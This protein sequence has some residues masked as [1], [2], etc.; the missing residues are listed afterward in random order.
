[1]KNKKESKNDEV[2]KLPKEKTIGIFSQDEVQNIVKAFIS[3]YLRG[4]VQI[5]FKCA[6]ELL[7]EAKLARRKLSVDDALEKEVQMKEPFLK[8]MAI[9]VG[10]K[11][12]TLEE[13]MDAVS[14]LFDYILAVRA[15]E[16]LK[17]NFMLFNPEKRLEK[18]EEDLAETNK[19]VQEIIFY[20]RSKDAKLPTRGS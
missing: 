10:T 6:D 11:K 14:M 15:S 8:Y 5:Q 9:C 12:G 16:R 3:A 20:L 17:G 18:L 19:L 4:D 13:R 7:K 1:M 2:V